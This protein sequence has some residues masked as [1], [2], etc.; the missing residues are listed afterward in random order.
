[1]AWFSAM[2]VSLSQEGRFDLNFEFKYI[3]EKLFIYYFHL[4]LKIFVNIYNIQDG[5]TGQGN[6]IDSV[7]RWP[8]I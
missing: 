6:A 2:V 1:M 7:E 8:D 4:S 5:E 3:F